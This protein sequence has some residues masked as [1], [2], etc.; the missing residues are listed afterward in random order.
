MQFKNVGYIPKT[1]GGLRKPSE[2]FGLSLENFAFLFFVDFANLWKT[3]LITD[4]FVSILE[5]N[6]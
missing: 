3:V 1:S 2:N 5:E 4:N 6:N